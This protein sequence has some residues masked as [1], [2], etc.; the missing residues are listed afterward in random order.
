MIG[1]VAAHGAELRPLR[2]QLAGRRTHEGILFG[3]LRGCPVA[4][5]VI[6]EGWAR[7]HDR[8]LRFLQT[9]RPDGLLVIG[10][11]GATAAGWAVGDM[12]L[13]D[14]VVDLR[15]DEDGADGPSYRPMLPVAAWRA[16]LGLRGG[17]VGTVGAV[18]VEPWDK[19]EL[20][21]R[22]GMTAVDLETA[23]VAAAA[24]QAA[25][26]WAAARA[27]LDPVD[28]PLAVVSP[29]H[30]AVLAMSVV[31]WSRLWRFAREL[32][33]AQRQLGIQVG[34]VVEVMQRTLA[35]KDERS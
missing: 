20:G 15:R 19:V 26:P 10:F 6:G 8:T 18:V 25:V 31:G 22:T 12:V 27:V 28:R 35:T 14:K 2:R 30:A 9:V 29:W 7:A 4:L 23:A 17:V 32:A 13:P 34:N 1:I 5:R 21:R 24:T 3:Q 16:Q 11:A 33:V